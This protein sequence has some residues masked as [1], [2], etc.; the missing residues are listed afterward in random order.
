M[1]SVLVTPTIEIVKLEV[2][3]VVVP[4]VTRNVKPVYVLVEADSAGVPDIEP[5]EGSTVSDEGRE[6]LPNE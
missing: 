3:R 2:V 1:A 4:S 5:V 6:P